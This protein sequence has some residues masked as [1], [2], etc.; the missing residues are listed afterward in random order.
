[1]TTN[2][3]LQNVVCILSSLLKGDY[4]LFRFFTLLKWK[5]Q[6]NNFHFFF[7]YKKEKHEIMQIR[8]KI[9]LKIIEKMLIVLFLYKVNNLSTIIEEA[10]ALYFQF[11][12]RLNKVLIIGIISK[13]NLLSIFK[14]KT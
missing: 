2:E 12:N 4:G 7:L 3:I 6:W 9:R 14:G 5:N 1:M 13:T 11:K 8:S 10:I